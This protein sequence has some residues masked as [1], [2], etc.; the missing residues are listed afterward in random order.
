MLRPL[1]ALVIQVREKVKSLA[2]GVLR[3]LLAALQ[4]PL[5]SL[6]S[7]A[8]SGGIFLVQVADSVQE[9][10]RAL[11]LLAE[12]GAA[13]DLRLALN[14]LDAAIGSASFSGQAGIDAGGHMTAIRADF[15]T[16]ASLDVQGQAAT[17]TA[18]LGAG[19]DAPDLAGAL[20]SAGEHIRGL[21]PASLLSADPAA[22]I[23][24]AIASLFDRFDLTPL[25]NELDA[26]GARIVAKLE[27]LVKVIATGL[28]KL[29]NEFFELVLPIT[30]A[31]ILEQIQQGIAASA[32][33]VRSARPCGAGAGAAE[34]R[35]RPSRYAG[36]VFAR[37]SRRRARW[38]VRLRDRQGSATRSGAIARRSERTERRDRQRAGIA[39][40]RRARAAHRIHQGLQSALD[41]VLSIDLAQR[42]A[43]RSRSCGR[44]SKRSWP[45]SKRSSKRCSR[46][47]KGRQAEAPV[48][49]RGSQIVE[50]VRGA[51]CIQRDARGRFVEIVKADGEHV[52]LQYNAQGRIERVDAADTSFETRMPCAGDPTMHVLDAR[53]TTDVAATDDAWSIIR[54]GAELS[55][56]SNADGRPLRVRIPGCP[57]PLEFRYTQHG[58]RLQ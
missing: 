10:Y 42:C 24:S 54:N 15:S 3:D 50:P 34:Y 52:R 20:R 22:D 4:G 45:P 23:A 25:A 28:V 13:A 14:E 9:R 32:C 2:E 27:G 49:V 56:Q 51:R 26:L 6:V 18:K 36:H 33:R 31:G 47:W 37:S 30:P 29:L 19:L 12:E 8:E 7:L 35:R 44:S 57:L 16:H 53:G 58:C 38:P 41:A 11:D 1:A 5:R 17:R 43:R 40:V 46:S 55:V 48:S 21:V 39:A